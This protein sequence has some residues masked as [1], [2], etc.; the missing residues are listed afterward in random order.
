[1]SVRILIVG[2]RADLVDGFR[3]QLDLPGLEVIAGTGAAG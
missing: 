1:M 2:L 3:G